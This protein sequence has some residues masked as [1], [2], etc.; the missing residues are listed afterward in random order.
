[1]YKT[2]GFVKAKIADKFNYLPAVFNQDFLEGFEEY[3]RVSHTGLH[4]LLG[5]EGR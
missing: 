1:V 3:V 5:M 2:N 4:L